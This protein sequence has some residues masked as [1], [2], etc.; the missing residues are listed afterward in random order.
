[1]YTRCTYT[2]T[3]NCE[4]HEVHVKCACGNA[5]C[6]HLAGSMCLA[7]YTITRFEIIKDVLSA[8]QMTLFSVKGTIHSKRQLKTLRK[9]F[10]HSE[11]PMGLDKKIVG[12]SLQPIGAIIT[13]NLF[14]KS[15]T[16]K[17]YNRCYL[18]SAARS[19]SKNFP[20]F[21]DMSVN[22]FKTLMK[23][24]KAPEMLKSAWNRMGT[25]CSTAHMLHAELCTLNRSLFV[26]LW[27]DP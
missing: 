19:R 13:G 10:I 14:M 21:S 26:R 24:S 20:V 12:N 18:I 1:M 3:P 9:H 22:P 27:I 17:S 4:V 8:Y 16:L 15:F 2:C 5:R 11:I 6:T 7:C 25:R 23:T